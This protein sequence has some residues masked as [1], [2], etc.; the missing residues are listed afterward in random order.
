MKTGDINTLLDKFYN[1]ETSLEEEALLIELFSQENLAEE[2]E[3]DR[4]VVVALSHIQ[5]KAPSSLE[6]KI[7]VLIDS[8]DQK[9]KSLQQK[10]RRILMRMR[11][12]GV[13]ASV[14]II[15]AIAMWSQIQH[16]R[17]D[18]TVADT[19]QTP[20]EAQAATIQALQLFSQHFS[21]GMQPLKKADKQ[22]EQ[23]QDIVNK[24]V[25]R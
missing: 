7:D 15:I 18:K 20:E 23:T 16:K 4:K 14:S 9:E 1:G 25:R 8:F 13:A 22:L 17:V 10:S 3:A 19:F 6:Q 21:K 2:W 5:R 12:I 11:L 24:V